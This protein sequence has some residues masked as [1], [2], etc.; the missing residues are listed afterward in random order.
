MVRSTGRQRCR[1][2]DPDQGVRSHAAGRGAAGYDPTPRRAREPGAVVWRGEAR[3]RSL[4]CCRA[5][6]ETLS[7]ASHTSPGAEA[8][9]R[10]WVGGRWSAGG[11]VVGASVVNGE[12]PRHPPDLCVATPAEAVELILRAGCIVGN[13][14]RAEAGDEMRFRARSG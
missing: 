13:D 10:R 6:G 12:C 7:E 9:P 2:T 11:V 5:N 14:G 1:V 3:S 4:T 8:S